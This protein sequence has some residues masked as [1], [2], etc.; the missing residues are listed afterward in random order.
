LLSAFSASEL[1]LL[2][3]IHL[4]ASLED[5][6][7]APDRQKLVFDLINWCERNGK[8]PAL[9]QGAIA[10]R[11]S[12]NAG[13]IALSGELNGHTRSGASDL[14]ALYQL[15]APPPD[16]NDRSADLAYLVDAVRRE[17]AGVLGVFGMAGVGKTALA[18]KLAEQLREDFPDAQLFFNLRGSSRGDTLAPARVMQQAIHA[19]TPGQKLPED[20]DELAALYRSTLSG[21]K[22]LLVL[23]NAWG[24]AQVEALL[25][26]QGW[27][28][29]VT[30]RRHV[31]LPGMRLRSL[32]VLEP[33]DAQV[34]LTAIAP[35]A[36]LQAVR[37]AELC[38]NL[39]MAL[40]VA[41]SL[42]ATRD[43]LTPER[44][45]ERL[46]KARLKELSEVAASLRVSYAALSKAQQRALRLLSIFQSGF[47]QRACQAVCGLKPRPAEETLGDLLTLSLLI[48]SP[49]A[50]RY[51]LHDLVRLFANQQL[52]AAERAAAQKRHAVYFCGLLGEADEAY[53]RGGSGVLEGLRLFDREWP[54][55]QTGFAW[56]QAAMAKD[57]E[58]ARL[59]N[60]YP[61]A[62]HYCMELRLPPR[63]RIAWLETALEAARKLGDRRSQGNHLLNLAGAH[64]YI[65]ELEK[66]DR[67]YDQALEIFRAAGDRLGE[68]K[69]LGGL[70]YAFYDQENYARSEELYR[71]WL[72][73]AQQTVDRES[74]ASALGGL[75]QIY[76]AQG[77][78]SQA[79]EQFNQ[80]LD[81][82]RT[83]GDRRGES[84]ALGNLGTAFL[85]ANDLPKAEEHALQALKID[86]E[87]GDR[88]S[89]AVDNWNLGDVYEAKGELEKAVAA[90][91]VYLDYLGEIGHAQLEERRQVVEELRKRLKA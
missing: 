30:S 31:N 27:L 72:T 79:I 25:P 65:D 15:P 57:R 59:V 41:G 53:L 37:I 46:E 12:N 74:Q 6:S 90:K 20:G 50:G 91:Q 8:L 85:Q 48:Y 2:A 19:F 82:A 18:L 88:D 54:N 21:K 52:S 44:L 5:I 80:Q 32:D 38:G 60:E 17:G 62:G 4:D 24:K 73:V 67:L 45:V 23:D 71:Q 3:R 84:S 35:R 22:G 66:A 7:L 29:I 69:A 49:E 13:L 39:P 77:K 70:A 33:A 86:R 28:T 36:A 87:I 42:L 83:Y 1:E 68:S 40:R 10:E 76:L 56:A 63:E 55:A 9:L 34:L 11:P 78:V 14:Q 47:D 16:F 51:R 26:P 43:D 64:V 89:E 81:I 75:G 61:Y 58:A